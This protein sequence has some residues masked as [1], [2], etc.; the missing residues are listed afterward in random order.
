MTGRANVVL[1]AISFVLVATLP[2]AVLI[3]LLFGQAP[4][5]NGADVAASAVRVPRLATAPDA[6]QQ[7]IL[8]PGHPAITPSTAPRG[9]GS[10]SVPLAVAVD[11]AGDPAA[12][13][14]PAM[15]FVF[16]RAA[17]QRMPLLVER[18]AASE[19]PRSVTLKVPDDPG[20]G[21]EIVAR[22]SRNGDVRL[23]P[24]DR[25]IVRSLARRT[26]PVESVALQIP[27]VP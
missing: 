12:L 2:S 19:L 24:E 23:D 26:G 20:T 15:V 16:V 3:W 11:Y 4:S 6:P 13:P 17:G 27:P 7:P 5:S 9:P 10:S 1:K 18:F 14:E 8:P 21:L 22:L 25:E